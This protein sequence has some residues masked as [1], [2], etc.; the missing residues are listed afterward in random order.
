[1]PFAVDSAG[2]SEQY[3]NK[4]KMHG[5]LQMERAIAGGHGKHAPV[6]ALCLQV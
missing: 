5:S 2:N 1:M 4:H 6:P 3:F